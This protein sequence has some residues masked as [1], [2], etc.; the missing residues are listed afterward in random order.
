MS[1]KSKDIFLGEASCLKARPEPIRV[2]VMQPKDDLY[3]SEQLGPHYNN[4]AHEIGAKRVDEFLR[5]VQAKNAELA[6]A[7]EYFLLRSSALEIIQN[8]MSLRNDTLYILPMET[9]TY[10]Q[11][12]EL[13]SLAESTDW[14]ECDAA[15]MCENPEEGQ[16]DSRW[17]NA[18][19]VAY[20]NENTRKIFFQP[21]VKA[22]GLEAGHIVCGNEVLAFR[23]ENGV[24]SLAICS[25][26][27]QP[28]EQVWKK[29]SAMGS[30]AYVVHCQFNPKPDYETYYPDFWSSILNAEDGNHRIIFSINWCRSSRLIGADNSREIP[31]QSNRFLRGRKIQKGALYRNRSH[32]GLHLQQT[33][34]SESPRNIWEVWHCLS[35][36]ENCRVLDFVRPKK[37][38]ARVQANFSKGIV[39]TE[40]FEPDSNHVFKQTTPVDL[41]PDFFNEIRRLGMKEQ[42]LSE[43]NK[44]TLCEIE[45]FNSSCNLVDNESWLQYNVDS[46]VPTAYLICTN[47][48]D[49]CKECTHF[50]KTC[51]KT[52]RFWVEDTKKMVLSL[53]ALGHHISANNLKVIFDV[54]RAYPANLLNQGT[55]LPGWLAHGRGLPGRNIGIEIRRILEESKTGS[56]EKSLEL[57]VVGVDGPLTENNILDVP[58]D[59]FDADTEIKHDT[60]KDK[61]LPILDIQVL[62]QN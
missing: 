6:I 46:R 1:L 8:P 58:V 22:S 35:T 26:V 49:R 7:P 31:R 54:T 57:Y 30:F 50:G 41:A 20:K 42:M 25:D 51:S 38:V 24:L 37:E 16:K 19:F 4:G 53:N 10:R 62:E 52:K 28:V 59:I 34:Q 61:H 23:G 9:M 55:G 2:A 43:L 3:Y 48:Q 12:E 15:E 18:A 44:L 45:T 14:S 56:R 17:V 13:L 60:F 47:P 39:T 11:Y 29:I 36:K 5:I 32:S 21:K 33:T 40:Y 27:N